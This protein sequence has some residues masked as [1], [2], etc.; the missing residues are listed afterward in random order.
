LVY[1]CIWKGIRTTGKVSEQQKSL[2]LK[3]MSW[4]KREVCLYLLGCV[5]DCYSALHH[6][7]HIVFPRCHIGWSKGWDFVF[8]KTAISP[9]WRFQGANY[10]ILCNK[11]N[12]DQGKM[13][14]IY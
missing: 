8:C 4:L 6:L 10:V 3:K 2:F 9:S 1:F 11:L 7:D 14:E 13:N 12:F 5:C